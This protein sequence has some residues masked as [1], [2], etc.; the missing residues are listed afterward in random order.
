[1]SSWP[2]TFNICT[3]AVVSLQLCRLNRTHRQ[4]VK[5]RLLTEKKTSLICFLMLFSFPLAADLPPQ[6]LSLASS[7]FSVYHLIWQ[8]LLTLLYTVAVKM[9][10]SQDSAFL[11]CL[12]F[13]VWRP[14]LLAAEQQTR[15]SAISI[16][17]SLCK[18]PLYLFFFFYKLQ[19]LSFCRACRPMWL[20]AACSQMSRFEAL[21]LF[22]HPLYVALCVSS[23][24]QLQ[25]DNRDKASDKLSKHC[26]E[27]ISSPFRTRIKLS[28]VSTGTQVIVYS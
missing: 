16:L 21:T 15:M 28:F 12:Q 5:L 3:H 20:Q 25:T 13:T 19:L 10:I 8:W 7:W 23:W 14:H 4:R 1:M 24:W 22:A 27:V 2:Y 26:Q 18:M 17:L 9:Q 11:F 6:I